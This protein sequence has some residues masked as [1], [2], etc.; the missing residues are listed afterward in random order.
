MGEKYFSGVAGFEDCFIEVSDS[1]TMKEV[2]E[3]TDSGEE[4]Y[5]DFFRKKV[6]SM[7]LRDSAGREFTNPREIKATDMDDFDIA[8]IGFFG[9]ILSLHVRK[10]KSLGN[11]NVLQ[12]SLMQGS[13]TQTKTK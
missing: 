2:R 3:L 1:W 13:S 12:S 8:L 4:Q 9:G 11:L 5:F 7:F 6:E 10:R